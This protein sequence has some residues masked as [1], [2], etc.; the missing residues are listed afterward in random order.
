MTTGSFARLVCGRRTKWV[1]LALWIVVLVFA[2]SLAGKLGGVEKNDNASWLP[3]DAEAT[4]VADLQKQFQPDDLVPAILVYE[5]T[6]GITP[7]D[8]EKAAADAK[9]IASVAGVTGQI[10]G[11]VPSEDKAALQVIA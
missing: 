10:I 11:P 3:G 6:G 8:Q 5:R 4:Q 2:G 1:V 9:A 7:A